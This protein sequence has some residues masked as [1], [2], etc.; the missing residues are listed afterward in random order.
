MM[1]FSLILGVFVLLIFLVMICI[2]AI[3]AMTRSKNEPKLYSWTLT[4]IILLT[5]NWI[6]YI[7]GFY[8]L[9]PVQLAE[10][11]FVPVWTVLVIFGTV[12][13]LFELRNNKL[14]AISVL[15]L[16]LISFLFS[17]FLYFIGS[18]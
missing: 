1:G 9:L 13:G 14:I 11:I 16:T 3:L 2:P 18:M 7:T 10:L 15:G 17:S 6:L 12:A 4:A 5:L 8:T